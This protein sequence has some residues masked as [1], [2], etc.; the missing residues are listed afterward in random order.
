M[1]L[2]LTV[3]GLTR[4]QRKWNTGSKESANS[5]Y[6]SK[7][8]FNARHLGPSTLSLR[9]VNDGQME[10]LVDPLS[11]NLISGWFGE[12]RLTYQRIRSHLTKVTHK[13]WKI[14]MGIRR[15]ILTFSVRMQSS[16]SSI[17]Q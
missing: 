13:S 4:K 16:Y 10:T 9:N 2:V 17:P 7:G 3:T 5:Y 15:D 12:E 8:G 11:F 1:V 14:L 6:H